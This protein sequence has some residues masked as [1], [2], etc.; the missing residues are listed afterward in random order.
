MK[1]S[2]RFLA[3]LLAFAML[4]IFA[5]CADNGES[6]E[7]EKTDDET[8]ATSEEVE[9]DKYDQAKGVYNNLRSV[10]F[11]GE[12]FTIV[13]QTNLGR[14]E[15]EIYVEEP[16]PGNVI[17][18]SV[19][20][21]NLVIN[22]K[23]DIEIS[24]LGSSNP[25]KTISEGCL[26][27]EQ[28][29]KFVFPSQYQCATLAKDGYLT[30]LLSLDDL[31]LEA[32]WWESGTLNT[33]IDGKCFFMCGDINFFDN[34]VMYILFF[35]KQEFENVNDSNP[36]EIVQNGE[37][38]IDV[39]ATMLTDYSQDLN[40]DGIYDEE[41]QY[42]FCA[43]AEYST[44]FF[45]GAG[46]KWCINDE[47]GL[48]EINTE[49][50]EKFESYFEKVYDIF[51]TANRTNTSTD[52]DLRKQMF[53]ED[54]VLFYGEVLSYV[55]NL[56]DMETPFGCLPIPKYTAEQDGYYTYTN[57]LGSGAA[58]PI[59]LDNVDDVAVVFEAFAIQ[60]YIKVT[61]SYYD[62]SLQRKYSRDD[63]SAAMLDIALANKTYDIAYLYGLSCANIYQDLVTS[64]STKF[65]SKYSSCIKSST[66]SL[67]KIV[68]AFEAM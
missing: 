44:T 56:K 14:A 38:T 25:V 21:R 63:E 34:D 22:E 2:V 23:Y 42:G 46:F 6:K 9:T 16:T 30:D 65:A 5:A 13:T 28:S 39:F 50:S 12:T 17:E 51:H 68:S 27:G 31:D 24:L 64:K 18:E 4:F 7:T 43:G 66:S 8:T 3:F 37:W 59:G 10:T 45:Y 49:D 47:Y 36:Y 40:G 58:I 60:S 1:K 54:R 55:E 19:Y 32:E 52:Y 53:E 11:D 26:A 29:Y 57:S 61:P 62:I 20:A 35:N 48:P 67:N 33:Q 41:D 15:M